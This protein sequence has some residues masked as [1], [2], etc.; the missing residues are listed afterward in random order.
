MVPD[1]EDYL[2]EIILTMMSSTSDHVL[3]KSSMFMSKKELK[4]T[5]GMLALKEKFEYR[6]KRSSMTC[7]KASH[8]D[9]GFK[10]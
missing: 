1:F 6:I 10:F 7:F 3:Y 9:I 8:K 4:T 2:I 5:L